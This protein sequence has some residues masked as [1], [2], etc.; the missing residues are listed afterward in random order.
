MT[1]KPTE[2]VAA[3]ARALLIKHE[4]VRLK[5]YKC[6]GGFWTL[7]VGRN[8]EARGQGPDDYPKGISLATAMQWLDEDIQIAADD[9]SAWIPGV[10]E[11]DEN[12]QAA[13]IDFAFQLGSKKLFGFAKARAAA[14][15][16]QWHTAAEEMRDSEWAKQDG[17]II[18]RAPRITGII[19]TGFWPK[20]VT[21]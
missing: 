13:F 7:G 1:W 4:G 5:A 18:R 12:R 16:M 17:R 20:D 6:T 10:Y 8:I 9:V 19:E 15:A 11:V 2:E 14:Q 3:K 21:I